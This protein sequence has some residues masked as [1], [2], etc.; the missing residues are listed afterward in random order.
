MWEAAQRLKRY[1][2]AR[3]EYGR[4]SP[5]R[6]RP[7]GHGH[8]PRHSR[9][10]GDCSAPRPSSTGIALTWEQ[11]ESTTRRPTPPR[12]PTP[13]TRST[14][15]LWRR[16]VGVGCLGAAS[17]GGPDPRCGPGADRPG[18]LAGSAGAGSRPAAINSAWFPAVGPAW[19]ISLA[20]MGTD[21]P[22]ARK[23]NFTWRAWGIRPGRHYQLLFLDE[24]TNVYV[25]HCGHP[26]AIYPYY[27]SRRR[28]WE[29]PYDLG[30]EWITGSCR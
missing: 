28:G 21:I 22:M 19:W 13:A 14:A 16:I 15:A 17:H 11:I 27:I 8:D 25:H 12:P 4:H 24:G 9:A 26:T 3:Q 18:L 20:A 1:E 10:A 30:T 2:K 5:G 7:F 6:P 29:R 23:S